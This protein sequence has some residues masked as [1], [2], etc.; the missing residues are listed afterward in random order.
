MSAHDLDWAI[1]ILKEKFLSR[2]MHAAECRREQAFM[3]RINP[4]DSGDWIENVRIRENASILR[5][6]DSRI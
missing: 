3:C 6:T 5:T 4:D 1:D 2:V